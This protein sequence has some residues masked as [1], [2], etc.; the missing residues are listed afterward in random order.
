M[1]VPR[2]IAKTSDIDS[3]GLTLSEL[4]ELWLGAHPTSGSCF[5]T[6]E[7]LVAAWAAGRAVV[8][9][10]WGS[11][12]RRPAGYYEFEYA[13][14][15]PPYDLERSTLWREDLLTVEE[16]AELEAWWK[17]EFEKAHAPDFFISTGSEV[18]HGDA[19]VQ[20]H[21][22]W[23]DVPHELARRWIAAQNA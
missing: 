10:L 19:A 5:C 16:K 9:R 12:G 14:R 22:R 1:P 11:H 4:Q 15:R 17:V 23:A 21:L 20:A 6:R 2:A 3:C 7:E 8:M 18:L 13:G